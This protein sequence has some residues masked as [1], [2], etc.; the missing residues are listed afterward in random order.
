MAWFC[1]VHSCLSSQRN[2]ING[3]HAE[4]T[5]HHQA[6]ASHLTR[7]RS[8]VCG[9]GKG[10]SLFLVWWYV[11]SKELCGCLM[12]YS[13]SRIFLF[14]CNEIPLFRAGL[15]RNF[16]YLK[17]QQFLFFSVDL[18]WAVSVKS[19]SFLT[20]IE[21]RVSVFWIYVYGLLLGNEWDVL[22]IHR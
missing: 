12:L 19:F 13:V 22:F 1:S 5:T 8:V 3:Y 15:S 10:G 6:F 4:T 18:L 9:E 17:R 21:Y 20:S 7:R 16:R 11:N 2:S 14:L